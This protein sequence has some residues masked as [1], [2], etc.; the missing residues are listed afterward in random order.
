MGQVRLYQ[1][2]D[3]KEILD[4]LGSAFATW[5]NFQVDSPHYHWRWKYLDNTLGRSIV[6]V[7][8]EKGKIIGVNHTLSLEVKIGNEVYP[9]NLLSDAA[10]NPDFRNQGTFKSMAELS[11]EERDKSGSRFNYWVT[12]N[13]HM[14]KRGLKF[15][16]RFPHG[17]HNLVR[18][19]DI[20][21]QLENMSMKRKGLVKAGF[22]LL[23]KLNSVIN[24]QISQSISSNCE[25][26]VI[27]KF[28]HQVDELCSSLLEAHC[29]IVK[30][31]RHYLNWRYM[32]TRAGGYKIIAAIEEGKTAGF[33]VLAINQT[34]N[35]Y[36][37]GYIVDL[38]C[39]PGRLDIASILIENS[40]A[41][42]DSE[43]LNIISILMVK[44]HPYE[45]ILH[46]HGFINSRVDPYLFYY[47]TGITNETKNLRCHPSSIYFSYGDIDSLPTES[48]G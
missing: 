29:F 19:R 27:Q 42:F 2:G 8:E 33:I 43:K 18:I 16:Q 47:E 31:D 12:R 39:N 14:I 13:P 30:R 40:L 44:G 45:N 1:E 35:N 28:N 5:P 10:V 20:D 26:K 7:A 6:V 4:L 9:A 21:L 24:F 34:R 41:Y 46:Q 22:L 11:I 38:Q 15:F 3:E 32:D 25:I 37:V 23:N 17:I 36:Q 48:G